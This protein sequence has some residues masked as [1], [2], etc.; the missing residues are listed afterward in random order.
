MVCGKG[1]KKSVIGRR[2]KQGHSYSDNQAAPA[3][4]MEVADVS[5]SF[6]LDFI[7][8]TKKQRPN[9]D[10]LKNWGV[11]RALTYRKKKV[12]KLSLKIND[13]SKKN[14]A[15]QYMVSGK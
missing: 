4:A 12:E 8:I 1:S 2:N 11:Q 14:N 6:V 9:N 3:A 5:N 13:L 7:P 10:L 15:L